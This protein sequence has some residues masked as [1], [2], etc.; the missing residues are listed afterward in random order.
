MSDLLEWVEKAAIENLKGHHQSADQIA[1]DSVQTLTVFL[2]IMTGAVAYAANAFQKCQFDWISV[3][4]TVFTGWFLILSILLVWKCLPMR[5][6]PAIFNEPN[7]LYQ[8][9]YSLDLMREAELGNF[10]IRIN[11][12]AARNA[13]IAKWLNGLRLAAAA[14][15]LVFTA[16]SA[17]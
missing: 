14:S 13:R 16:S 3:G 12:A 15:P 8:P 4:A 17:A 1:K 6:M 5:E 2:L 11:Q 9:K 10:Q 7:N